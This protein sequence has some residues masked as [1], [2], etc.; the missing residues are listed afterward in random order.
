MLGQEPAPARCATRGAP[1][2]LYTV[3]RRQVPLHSYTNLIDSSV[4]P[5]G[6]FVLLTT[7]RGYIAKLLAD[8]RAVSALYGALRGYKRCTHPQS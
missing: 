5:S 6:Q 4:Q 8:N 3:E 7:D 1:R 2:G